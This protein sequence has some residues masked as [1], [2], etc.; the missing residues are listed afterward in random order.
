MPMRV[1]KF[2]SLDEV[3]GIALLKNPDGL[4]PAT[5]NLTLNQSKTRGTCRQ[6]NGI[7]GTIALDAQTTSDLLC[8]VDVPFQFHWTEELIVKSVDVM[9]L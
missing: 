8:Y 4:P 2:A 7:Q 6:M 9:A 3:A 1:V 5:F